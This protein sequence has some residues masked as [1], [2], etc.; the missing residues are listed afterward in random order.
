M[1]ILEYLQQVVYVHR[2]GSNLPIEMR[3][4]WNKGS[5]N[6]ADSIRSQAPRFLGC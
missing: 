3:H 5:N 6:I 2:L 4:E 1:V